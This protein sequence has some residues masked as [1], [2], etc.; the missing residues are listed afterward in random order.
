MRKNCI[1]I[2]DDEK[3]V[4]K[5]LDKVFKKEGYVT[6]T[7]SSG[8]EALDIL[9]EHYVD[10]V[11]TD[12][13][14]PGM[15]GIELLSE[16]KKIDSSINVILIT[17]FA[18]VETAIE[19][20]KMG[21][22]DYIVKPFKLED[23]LLSVNN[24]VGSNEK[25]DDDNSTQDYF[26]SK[27]V[28]MD[29]VI[30]LI[31]QVADSKTTIMIYGETGTGKELAAK[32]IYSLS[33]RKDKPF[34]KVNCAAIPETLLESELFGYEKGAFTGAT[35]SKPGR[36]E[37]ADGGTIFLDEI[38]DITPLMQVKLLRV[39]QEKE[40]ER[41]GGT[42]TIK[43]DV[44]IIAATNKD[45]SEMVKKEKF[46]QDLYYRLNVVPIKLP[47]LRERK[48][49]IPLLAEYFLL[50]SSSISGKSKKDMSQE[51]VERLMYYNWPGNIRELENVIERCVVIKHGELIG[52]E[53]LPEYIINYK[54][55]KEERVSYKLNSAV[56]TA[57]RE[58]ILKTL[59][60]C[61]GNKTKAS[62]VLGISRRSL[63]RKIIK[64]NIEE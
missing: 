47:P 32:A 45:L 53:D 62:E 4:T 37:L 54:E 21:A 60:E 6:H 51:A 14:M 58:T 29:K 20:L 27:S 13:K 39:L 56:D 55:D 23:V 31:K 3:N 46:R 1:L 18:T 50:K 61:N 40:F 48:E 16:I 52:L 42:K 19:A 63:H 2:V 41:L 33:D 26:T 28:K 30:D 5:L 64:Y 43:V 44:R 38:G 9:N 17:A 22:K 25:S 59:K 11:V 49:D 35:I 10:V 57:E 36:F 12:I 34:I 24:V 7:A 8:K 15:N